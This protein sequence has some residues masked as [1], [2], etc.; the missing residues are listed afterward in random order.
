MAKFYRPDELPGETSDQNYLEPVKAMEIRRLHEYYSHPSVNEMKRMANEWFKEPEVTPK[1]IEIWYTREGKFCSGCVEGKLKEH[2]R[3]ASTKPL[4]A[5][6]PGEN[7]VGD[8]MFIESRNYVKTPFYVHVDVATKLIIGYAMKDK[9][10]G[11]VLRAIEYVDEQHGLV[12]HK[13]ERLIRPRVINSSD[14]RGHRCPRDQ[15]YSK[16]GG[17]ESRLGRS[18]YSAHYREGEGD[19]GWSQSDVWL[20]PSEPV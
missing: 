4:V 17:S 8:L 9:T 12:R 18:I 7:G 3:R 16:G 2:A 15:A 19:E 20:H 14:A 11:E 1:E 6:E 5:T 10:Y 13:L